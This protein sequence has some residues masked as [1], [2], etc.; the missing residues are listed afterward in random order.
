MRRGVFKV[1]MPENA[2]LSGSIDQIDSEFVER[3]AT[4]RF[5]I[6]LSIQL[7]LTELSLSNTVS[8]FE[9]FGVGRA[10]STA[11]NWVHKADLQP[12]EGRNPDQVAV[13]ETVIQLD[14]EYYWPYAAVIPS[15]TNYYIQRLNQRQTARSLA[16]SSRNS[17]RN[18]TSMTPCFSLTGRIH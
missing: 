7:Y 4:P 11:H 6:K 1:S 15:Q 18:T 2:R 10:R 17:T 9:V 16:R 8:I 5:L 13:D 14:D 12:D 3:E